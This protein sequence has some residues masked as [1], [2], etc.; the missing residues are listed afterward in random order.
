MLIPRR[1]KWRSSTAGTAPVLRPAARELAFAITA[2]R[3]LRVPYVTNRRSC[4]Y[5]TTRS[6]VV[7]RWIN[8][9]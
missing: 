7:A 5:R 9:S 8:I 6:R 1:T 2:F 3:H 4:S